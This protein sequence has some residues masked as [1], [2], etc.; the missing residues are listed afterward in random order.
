M[1]PVA[2]NSL[3]RRKKNRGARVGVLRLDVEGSGPAGFRFALRRE[4]GP[5]TRAYR[6]RF[7]GAVKAAR[8]SS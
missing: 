4:R 3:L 6:E 5:E 8:G 7:V 1:C 2:H